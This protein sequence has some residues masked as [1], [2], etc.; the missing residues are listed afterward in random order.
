MDNF[1]AVLSQTCGKQKHKRTKQSLLGFCQT[2]LA[3]VMLHGTATGAPTAT[4][5]GA[6]TPP[7]PRTGPHPGHPGWLARA[8]DSFHP[9]HSSALYNPTGHNSCPTPARPRPRYSRRSAS[10]RSLRLLRRAWMST[11]KGCLTTAPTRRTMTSP[12]HSA[13]CF[14]TRASPRMRTRPNRSA[15]RCSRSYVAAWHQPRR[16]RPNSRSWMA[17]A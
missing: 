8:A 9:S 2:V 11:S 13:R 16:P 15:A 1:G 17:T 12:R 5:P 10:R 3:F 6:P 4:P 7:L 14:R